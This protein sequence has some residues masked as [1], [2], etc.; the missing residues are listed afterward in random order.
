[1]RGGDVAGGGGSAAS[2]AKK[3]RNLKGKKVSCKQKKM[4]EK[5]RDLTCVTLGRG[6]EGKAGHEGGG[7]AVPKAKKIE[8]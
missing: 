1:M 8:L 2:E 5:R 6:G 7:V 4:T 3:N